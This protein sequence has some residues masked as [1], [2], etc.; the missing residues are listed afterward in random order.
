MSAAFFPC[1]KRVFAWLSLG[2]VALCASSNARAEAK[3][4]A[5]SLSAQVICPPAASPGRIVCGL[6][7]RA[8]SGKLVWADALVVR[9]PAFARP[10]RSRVVAEL[11]AD[12]PN[13]A[14]AKLALVATELGQGELE[15]RVRAVVCREG[16]NGEACAPE[17]AVAVGAVSV[18]SPPQPPAPAP[19]PERALS[20]ARGAPPEFGRK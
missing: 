7:A 8:A 10:L 9:A 12:H 15:L 20:E 19:A 14:S 11:S 17:V 6:S 1:S 4:V 3:A 2:A 13:L 16:P 18:G 5:S